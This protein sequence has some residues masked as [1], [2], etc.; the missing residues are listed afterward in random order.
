MVRQ[1]QAIHSFDDLNHVGVRLQIPA[2]LKRGTACGRG[3]A[4]PYQHLHPLYIWTLY[5]S[6]AY[7][8]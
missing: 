4:L 8:A 5:K 2:Q 6:G 7:D 1:R 3:G